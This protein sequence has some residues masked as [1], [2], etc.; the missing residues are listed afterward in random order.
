MPFERTLKTVAKLG[1]KNS[2]ILPA[3]FWTKER[4]VVAVVVEF[5]ASFLRNCSL[6][7]PSSVSA[8]NAAGTA[9][10]FLR[11]L[12]SPSHDGEP[13]EPPISTPRY[14]V[15]LKSTDVSGVELPSMTLN[16]PLLTVTLSPT[17]VLRFSAHTAVVVAAVGDVRS[18]N[19]M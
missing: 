17:A 5:V 3:P 11:G 16:N 12:I 15:W 7:I 18:Q 9:P 6:E 19:F 2:A 10:S 4:N 1:P 14:S 13:L 8:T